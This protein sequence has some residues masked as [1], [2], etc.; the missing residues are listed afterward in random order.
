MRALEVVLAVLMVLIL[1][2][3]VAVAALGRLQ[4]ARV[5]GGLS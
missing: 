3:S 5:I 2:H 4:I 1:W